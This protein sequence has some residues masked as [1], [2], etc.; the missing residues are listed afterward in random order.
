MFL[1][2]THIEGIIVEKKT[3]QA[4]KNADLKKNRWSASL[5]RY[6]A[7][8]NMFLNVLPVWAD[9]HGRVMRLL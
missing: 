6:T 2:G 1:S 9:R 7:R 3:K 8:E 4:K 5:S